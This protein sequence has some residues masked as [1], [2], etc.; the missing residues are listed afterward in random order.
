MKKKITIIISILLAVSVA[1]LSVISAFA[2][3]IF[4]SDGY[5]YTFLNDDYIS[6]CD[7]DDSSDYLNIPAQIDNKYVKEIADRG[8]YADTFIT[9][10]SFNRAIYMNRI[11]IMAFKGCTGLSGKLSLPY[12]INDIG[13]S[14]FQDCGS[15]TSVE[16]Y[17]STSAVPDQCF[18]NCAG[19]NSVI[20]GDAVTSISKLA[21]AACPQLTY[22]RIPQNVTYIAPSAFNGDNDL[23]IYC[24]TDSYAH[25]YAEDKGIE[26]VLIDAPDPTEPPTEPE[27]T[28]PSP[29]DAPTE[30]APT[31][32]PTNPEPTQAAGY[33]LGDFDN[34]RKVDSIDVTYL[35]R[36]LVGISD[37][38]TSVLEQGD[39]DGDGVITIIDATFIQRYL[40]GI[41]TP[42]PIGEWISE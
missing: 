9:S 37:P 18:Y 10:V 15:I 5:S 27:P 40:A 16:Y 12:W 19:L 2:A 29:T 33:Y 3:T 38:E 8:L 36:Y 42:Y 20:I 22:V 28:E 26:Y 17:A 30:P 31:E 4:V 32:P 24:Y 34:D 21:F 6:I 25:Q 11:G 13:Y 14:A 23:V 1:A 35:Q 7:W 41:D 39:V